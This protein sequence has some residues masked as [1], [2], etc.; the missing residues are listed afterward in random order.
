MLK[1]Q[2]TG[3][4]IVVQQVKHRA[5]IPEDV[6]LILGLT[7]WAQDPAFLQAAV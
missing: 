2:E 4:L 3:V 5:S 6:D 1:D 7:Q